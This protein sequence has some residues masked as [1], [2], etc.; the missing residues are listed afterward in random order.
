MNGQ[1]VD[2]TAAADGGFDMN[3]TSCAPGHEGVLQIFP[4]GKHFIKCIEGGN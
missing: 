1:K 2:N 4:L 3:I